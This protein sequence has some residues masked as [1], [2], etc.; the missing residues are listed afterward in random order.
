MAYVFVGVVVIKRYAL[1][2]GHVPYEGGGF[3]PEILNRPVWMV[4]FG[5]IHADE[6]YALAG[7]QHES[8]PI[9]HSLNVF[10]ITGNY[11]AV[12]WIKETRQSNSYEECG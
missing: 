12:G 4:G 10:T 11:V 7:A 9:N 8:I 1:P 2:L 5:C 3:L 6:P